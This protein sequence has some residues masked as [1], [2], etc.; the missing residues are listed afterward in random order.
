MLQSNLLRVASAVFLTLALGAFSLLVS[1]SPH[2][3]AQEAPTGFTTPTYEDGPGTRSV[4]NGMPEPAGDSFAEDQAT[5]EEQE[6]FE[7]GLGPVFNAQACVACH[8]N[9][10]TGGTSQV[11]ELRVGHKDG[12]GNFVNPT[13]TINNGQS[14]ISG[15]SLINDRS[16]CAEAQ[17]RTPN[18]E[19]LRTFRMSLNTLGD[20]FV[21][22]VDS[23]VLI[24]ISLSQRVI[25]RGQIAGEVI[26]VPVLEAPVT[27]RVGRFGWKNQHASLLSFAS[28]AYLNEQGIT[29]RL[30]PTDTTSVCKTTS[31]PEDTPDSNG[32]EDIDRFATFMRATQAPPVDAALAA[33]PD[34]QAG[35]KL[36][37][38]VGCN[39]C[40][41]RTLITS[42]AGTAI[43][44][45]TFT[46]PPALGSK[47]FHPFSD[48]LLHDVGTGDGIVQNGPADTANK[49][50]TAPLWGLRTHDRLMHDGGSLT[51]SDAILRHAGEASGVINNY[52]GLSPHQKNQLLTFLDSL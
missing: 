29:N 50:R 24:G 44:G 17:E 7:K 46:V 32:M 49:F 27:T 11:S 2:Q 30:N 36:F 39:T 25:T 37:D 45:G 22:A 35:S 4:S 19:T 16:I 15:R 8:Q 40:H 48:F 52:R 3:S 34:A 33:T 20:G 38:Q 31:D 21:E 41:V 42:P 43:N 5:F 14:Q 51:R 6:G 18:S 47:M 23:N 28:D 12:S 13:V 10:V 1:Q 9:P 26:Q